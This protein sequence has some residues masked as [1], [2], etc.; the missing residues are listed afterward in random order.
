MAQDPSSN[1]VTR[2]A[3]ARTS[4]RGRRALA[5]ATAILVGAAGCR[6]TPSRAVTVVDSAGIR[7]TTSPDESRTFAVVDS[8]PLV[9]IGGPNATGPAQFDDVVSV[10]LESK[11]RIWVAD[12]GSAQLRIFNADGSP[13]KIQGGRGEGPR[14]FERIRI[15]GAFHGDTVGVWDARNRRLAMFDLD[16][17]FLGVRVLPPGALA[18]PRSYGVFQDGS[19]LAQVPKVLYASDLQPGRILRDTTRLVRLRLADGSTTAE[20]TAGGPIWLWTGRDQVPIP[21][22]VNPGVALSDDTVY[23]VDGDSFQVRVFANGRLA[24]VDRIARRP[25]PVTARSI[26]RYRAWIQEVVRPQRRSAFLAALSRP[27]RPATLPAYTEVMVVGDHVWAEVYQTGRWDV[28][29]ARG[30]FVGDVVT[31]PGFTAMSATERRVAGVWRG[32]SEVEYVRVYA[33]R[34]R[35]A[36]P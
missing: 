32:A 23:V 26:R 11:G 8:M 2:S 30:V 29:D 21:F 24:R 14:E 12:A 28:F 13:W 4:P 19:I 16:G 7:I 6:R 9:S 31:P 1:Q 22:T 33:L 3:G 20:A 35:A 34:S 36:E 27:E 17:R 18:S 5:C 25:Q 15:L 10:D